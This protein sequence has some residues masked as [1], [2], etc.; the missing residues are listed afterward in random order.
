MCQEVVSEIRI[1]SAARTKESLDI[2]NLDRIFSADGH[3]PDA[4]LKIALFCGSLG[5]VDGISAAF[6]G[7]PESEVCGILC[8]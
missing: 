5:V 3:R 8:K 4:L 2:A 7:N 1:L 6:A